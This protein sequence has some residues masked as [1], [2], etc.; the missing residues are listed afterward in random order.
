MSETIVK[1]KRGRK[2]GSYSFTTMKLGDLCAQLN[3]NINIV[4]SRKWVEAV[5]LTSDSIAK[6]SIE[7]MKQ[8]SVPSVTAPS[9][10]LQ[11][12]VEL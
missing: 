6:N 1:S 8:T 10:P 3:P 5:G 2:A 9:E 7:T 11:V 12:E 4:L